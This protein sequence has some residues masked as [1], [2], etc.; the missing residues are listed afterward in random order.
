M[1]L[2]CHLSGTQRATRF[3]QHGDDSSDQL[4]RSVRTDHSDRW[5]SLSRLP[6]DVET[7]GF[8]PDRHA[9]PEPTLALKLGLFGAEFEQQPHTGRWCCQ[10]TL[11]ETFLSL[12]L[13][14]QKHAAA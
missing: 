13:A 4:L 6:L 7:N 12:G 11:L 9:R 3:L 10:K 1:L 2:F 5:G 14:I 8:H